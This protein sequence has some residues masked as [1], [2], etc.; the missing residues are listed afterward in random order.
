MITYLKNMSPEQRRKYLYA[1]AAIAS[2]VYATWEAHGRNWRATAIALA[3]AAITKLAHAN[4]NDPT[5]AVT[6]QP[7]FTV[8][9]ALVGPEGSPDTDPES[10]D[11]EEAPAA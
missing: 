3:T 8:T 6:Q 7:I 4:V 5:A 11:A 1:A 10:G 9:S 2:L